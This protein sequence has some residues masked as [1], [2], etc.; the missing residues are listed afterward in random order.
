[1]HANKL[2]NPNEIKNIFRNLYTDKRR[3]NRNLNRLNM[4]TD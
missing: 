4:S 3:K 2:D 1:M